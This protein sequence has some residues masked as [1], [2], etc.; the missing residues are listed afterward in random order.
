MKKCKYCAEEIQDEAAYCRFCNRDLSGKQSGEPK[1]IIK[2]EKAKEGLF[3]QSM[4]AGCG[5]IIFIIIMI[6]IAIIWS[7]SDSAANKAKSRVSISSTPT[8]STAPN[9]KPVEDKWPPSPST[10]FVKMITSGSS[11]SNNIGKVTIITKPTITKEQLAVLNDSVLAHLTYFYSNAGKDA[12]NP[13]FLFI[14]Y[15]DN[16]TISKSYFQGDISDTEFTHYRGNYKLNKNSGL[17][18]LNW[19]NLS[20]NDWDLVKKY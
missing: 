18:E 20:S 9:T 19:H 7:M 11:D 3:L 10:G 12:F 16:E 4:N 13:T 6:V 5:C 1:V 2:K 8:T 14:D 15:F 17:N